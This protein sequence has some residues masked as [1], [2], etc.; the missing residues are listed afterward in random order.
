MSEWT[1]TIDALIGYLRYRQ[2]CGE[3]SIEMDPAVLAILTALPTAPRPGA[4]TAHAV[5]TPPAAARPAA[6]TPPHATPP[7]PNLPKPTGDSLEAREAGLAAI[8]ATVA[9]CQR[10]A[11]GQTRMRVEP[12]H[13]NPCAPEIMFVGEAPGAGEDAQTSADPDAAEQL[14]TKMIAAMGFTRDQVFIAHVCK[15]RLAK[16]RA[17]T[18]DE[19]QA[20]LPYLRA[21]LAIIRP[22]TIVA[23]GAVAVKGLLDTQAGISRLRGQWTRYGDVP[24]MPTFH[25]AYLLRY[26]TAKKNSWEDLKAVLKH[27]G[28]QA[29]ARTPAAPA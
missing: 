12:G 14:L 17:P 28:R 21:Q 5:S 6:A 18:A 9:A 15:C 19:M 7:T 1:E 27:L 16:H 22:K 23:L 8:A 2:E 29:P 24:L 3:R 10:C 13:G 20:C 11:L 4:A 26:P 25:P